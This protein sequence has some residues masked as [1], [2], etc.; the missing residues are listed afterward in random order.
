MI[1][2]MKFNWFVEENLKEEKQEEEEAILEPFMCIVGV[3]AMRI[4]DNWVI[5]WLVE[6]WT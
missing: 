3:G 4:D 1:Y 2:T 5:K 6:Q